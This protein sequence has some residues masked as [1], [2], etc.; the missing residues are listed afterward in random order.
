MD[1]CNE[2]VELVTI[3]RV[4]FGEVEATPRPYVRSLPKLCPDCWYT[5]CTHLSPSECRRLKRVSK[6]FYSIAQMVLR[7]ST[8]PLSSR[9]L[10]EL[11]LTTSRPWLVS[12]NLAYRVGLTTAH[13]A[14]L[15]NLRY[16]NLTS[17][18]S[19]TDVGI[20]V[21]TRL[22]TLILFN[23]REV[24]DVGIQCLTRLQTLDLSWCSELITDQGIAPLTNL[25]SLNLSRSDCHVSIQG[26]RPLTKLEHLDLFYSY[27][28]IR[29]RSILLDPS[30]RKV[31]PALKVLKIETG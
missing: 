5:I 6:T 30:W 25:T 21:L 29:V 27:G 9:E 19:V 15:T 24:S 3:Q 2:L 12:M 28:S 14:L 18:R 11:P 20:S 22:E 8:L 17:C 23:C 13:L 31:L 16:L 4:G 26:L 7:Q 10:Q 1:V